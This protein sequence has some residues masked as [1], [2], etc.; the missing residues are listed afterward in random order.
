MTRRTCK[1]RHPQR[2]MDTNA[3]GDTRYVK[4]VSIAIQ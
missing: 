1:S 4:V 2:I 3:V